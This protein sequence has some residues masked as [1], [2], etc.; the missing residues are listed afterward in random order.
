MQQRIRNLEIEMEAAN[1]P[2]KLWNL[3][4]RNDAVELGKGQRSG[5]QEL[6]RER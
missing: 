1:D 2:L 5:A 3:R 4:H 6:E